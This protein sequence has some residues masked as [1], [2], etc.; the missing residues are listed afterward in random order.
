MVRSWHKDRSDPPRV[1][2]LPNAQSLSLGL[3]TPAPHRIQT[4]ELEISL[5]TPYTQR[6]SASQHIVPRAHSTTSSSSFA[7]TGET[8][9]GQPGPTATGLLR[10]PSGRPWKSWRCR[11]QNNKESNDA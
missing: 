6:A 10:T 1:G 2:E 8:V 3:W 11:A 9:S 7:C 4:L 5:Q